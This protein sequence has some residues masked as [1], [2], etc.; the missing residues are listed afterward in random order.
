MR[1]KLTRSQ[2]TTGLVSKKVLF[3]L[4]AKVDYSAVEVA[5]IQKYNL[6]SQIIY[7]S[8]SARRHAENAGSGGGLMKSL[9]S[10]AMARM[11]LSVTIAS[12]SQGQ[13]IECKDLDEMLQAEE[14][15]CSACENLKNYLKIA[16]SF[17]GAEEVIE[18]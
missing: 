10:S 1:L 2:R 16:E 13:Q 3:V 11:S 15:I 14:A 7:D 4:G 12:L 8:E 6:G 5:C 9:A 17:D 18:F